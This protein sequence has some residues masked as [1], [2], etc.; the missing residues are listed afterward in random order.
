M[1]AEKGI[2]KMIKEYCKFIIKNC[3]KW[4]YKHKLTVFKNLVNIHKDG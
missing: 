4:N 3:K 2:E 1:S